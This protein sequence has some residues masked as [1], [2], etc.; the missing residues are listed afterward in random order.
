MVASRADKNSTDSVLYLPVFPLIRGRKRHLD[1]G[2]LR[3]PLLVI[4]HHQYMTLIRPVLMLLSFSLYSLWLYN[5]LDLGLFSSF[6]IL[7]TVGRT[8]WTGDQLV[9]RPLPTRRT[10]QTQNK[11]RDIHA[12]S[13]IRTHV[14]SVRA[15]ED[16]SCFRPRGH[17]DRLSLYTQ[18]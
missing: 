11:R 18:I 9:A 10:T 2:F 15:A 17:C 6:L 7:Y 12:S 8:P 13:G 5:P 16:G 1:A 3:F 4:E 14:P